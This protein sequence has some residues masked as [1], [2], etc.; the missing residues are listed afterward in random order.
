M[1]P[2]TEDQ[3]RDVGYS[4]RKMPLGM[5][6]NSPLPQFEP[7]ATHRVGTH[8]LPTPEFAGLDSSDLGAIIAYGC[9]R[10]CAKGAVLFSEGEVA[11]RLLVVCSGTIKAYMTDESGKQFILS[12]HGVGEVIGEA[13]VID[14]GIRSASVLTLTKATVCFVDRMAFFDCLAQRPQLGARLLRPMT[15]RIRSLTDKVKTLAFMDVYGRIARLLLTLAC[16]RNGV[17][18][19]ERRPTQKDLASMVGSSREMV[20]RIMGGL[21]AGQYIKIDGRELIIMRELPRSLQESTLA[22]EFSL[23]RHGEVEC[24]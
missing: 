6:P 2:G 17:L 13:D 1:K 11:D 8:A 12:M 14:G 20:S 24:S 9:V 16:E 19:V 21:A 3:N 7:D 15:Q 22:A 4:A 5:V 18:V 23:K 10:S